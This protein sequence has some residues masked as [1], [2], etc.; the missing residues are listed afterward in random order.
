MLAMVADRLTGGPSPMT[1]SSGD[2][3]YPGLLPSL[4]R[5]VSEPKM[6]TWSTPASTTSAMAD[7]AAWTRWHNIVPMEL[8]KK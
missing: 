2:T 4:T 7:T 8:S 6:V 1:R 3:D 5:I